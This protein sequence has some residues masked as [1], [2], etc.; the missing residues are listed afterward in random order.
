[1]GK[2]F[3]CPKCHRTSPW[4]SKYNM[5]ICTRCGEEMFMREEHIKN[6]YRVEVKEKEVEE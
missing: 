5:V 3:Y 1:M 4:D 2:V 6:V